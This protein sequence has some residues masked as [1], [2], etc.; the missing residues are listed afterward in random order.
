MKQII[1]DQVPAPALVIA[2]QEGYVALALHLRPLCSDTYHCHGAQGALPP[3]FPGM[4]PFR[5]ADFAPRAIC[6]LGN[7]VAVQSEAVLLHVNVA[8]A[9]VGAQSMLKGLELHRKTVTVNKITDTCW[10]I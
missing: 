9:V 7:R 1:V 8:R 6:A 3:D 5:K 10:E 2:A 4:S